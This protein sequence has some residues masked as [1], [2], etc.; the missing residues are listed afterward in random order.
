MKIVVYIVVACC[1]VVYV[2]VTHYNASVLCILIYVEGN[3]A[4]SLKSGLLDLLLAFRLALQI[5]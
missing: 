1:Y 4:G 2:C 5:L 3:F